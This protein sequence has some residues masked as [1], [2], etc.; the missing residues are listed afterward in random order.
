MINLSS[1][2]LLDI[3]AG[4]WKYID[5]LGSGGFSQPSKMPKVKGGPDGQLYNLA[6]D[7]GET[8]DL[9]AA[10]PEIVARLEAELKRLSEAGRSR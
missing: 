10:R 7:P 9:A 2:G 6:D 1:R 4:D 8:K 3:R 5:G